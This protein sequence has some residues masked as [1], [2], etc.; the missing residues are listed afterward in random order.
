MP[1]ILRLAPRC[2]LCRLSIDRSSFAE[3]PSRRTLLLAWFVS[4]AAAIRAL[5]RLPR[6]QAQSTAGDSGKARSSQCSVPMSS[7]A[8]RGKST[9]ARASVTNQIH[10]PGPLLSTAACKSQS[11]ALIPLRQKTPLQTS[12]STR[13][14]PLLPAQT[15]T[16]RAHFST[17]RCSSHPL[18]TPGPRTC[19]AGPRPQQPAA[20]K[21]AH[22]SPVQHGQLEFPGASLAVHPR[23]SSVC[24]LWHALDLWP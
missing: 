14:Q 1:K 15:R 10:Q 21:S 3:A 6:P 18:G 11:G 4:T 7:A 23:P 16:A 22:T 8:P 5:R 19:W 13:C 17:P 9:P 12:G 2:H 24:W 20:P